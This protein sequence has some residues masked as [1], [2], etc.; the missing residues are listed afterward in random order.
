MTKIKQ[1]EE[2]RLAFSLVEAAAAVGVSVPVMSEWVHIPGFPA[3]KS[4]TRWIIPV[5]S[6]EHWLDERAQA[7]GNIAG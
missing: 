6:L 2:I 1:N 5:S 4:G 3:F 7:G